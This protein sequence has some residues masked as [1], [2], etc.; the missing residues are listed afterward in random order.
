MNGLI[1]FTVIWWTV[2]FMVLPFWVKHDQARAKGQ[3]AGAPD[4][5]YLGRKMLVT[6]GISVFVW[7][8]ALWLVHNGWLKGLV[9]WM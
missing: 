3:Q 6:T 8:V 4:I 2:I 5:P 9:S 7:F 1:L